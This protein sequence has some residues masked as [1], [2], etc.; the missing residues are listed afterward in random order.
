[1]QQ[2]HPS[3]LVTG[4]TGFVL[5]NTVKY[6]LETYSSSL[7]IVLDLQPV[8]GHL[9]DYFNPVL[10]RLISIQG[11]IRDRQILDE[12]SSEWNL[13]HVVHAASLTHYKPWELENPVKYV[14]INI[15]GTTNLLEWVRNLHGL[16]QFM[17]ISTGDVYGESKND[18]TPSPQSET[19]PFYPP[20]F[21][22]FTKWSAENIIR[23][24][25]E[26]FNIPMPSVR[27]SSVFGPME[28]PTAGRVTMSLP[29]CI[30]RAMIEDRPFRTTEATLQAGG[31]FI[32]AEEI[33]RAITAII[34]TKRPLN[35]AYNIASGTYTAIRKILAIFKDIEPSFT[36][37]TVNSEQA[38]WQRDPNNRYAR[39][40]AYTI[41]RLRDEFDWRP[42]PLAEQ[43]N[44]YYQWVMESPDIRCPPLQKPPSINKSI[45]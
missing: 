26:I 43:L 34:R 7:L 40:D 20:E 45:S 18:E 28:R 4:G 16:Q 33:A 44:S 10:E 24:Y 42:S 22:A 3:I 36:Y 38:D 29:Y 17:Y 27:L 31:D 1:M 6:L 39:W 25:G 23:R 30:V 32:S 5:S 12:I 19:G 21:Y 14:D 9:C 11:D 15:M 13:T 37:E 41:Q 35:N 8:K 2:P